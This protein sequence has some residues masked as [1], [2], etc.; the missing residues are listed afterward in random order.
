[1]TE[2]KKIYEDELKFVQDITKFMKE[3]GVKEFKWDHIK[4][5]FEDKAPQMIRYDL[6]VEP[7]LSIEEV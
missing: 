2:D 4:V 7:S 3:I 5:K 6:P 1:M